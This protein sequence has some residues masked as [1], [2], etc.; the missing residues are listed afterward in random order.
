[1]RLVANDL[2]PWHVPR[3][4]GLARRDYFP[5]FFP[6]N[7]GEGFAHDCALRHFLPA[8]IAVQIYPG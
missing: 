2:P 1:M 7:G 8:A 5:D 3:E 4:V 6:V